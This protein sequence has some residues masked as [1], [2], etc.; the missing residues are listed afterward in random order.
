MFKVPLPK[1]P[2]PK[3]RVARLL[4]VSG[5]RHITP[6][7]IRVT[8]EGPELADIPQ[9]CAGAHC[10]IL[11]PEAGQSR[12]DFQRQ[13]ADGPKPITRTYT[14][15]HMRPDPLQ[16]DVDFVAHGDE[17]PASAWAHRAE[18][19]SFCGFMGPGG[20]KLN[21]YYA[22]WYLVAAD[23][24]ALPVA[25]ATIEAMPDD[26]KGIAIF[27]VTSEA[28]KQDFPTP[29]G[30]ETH[31]LIH[32]DAHHR[33]HAQEEFIRSLDWPEGTVQTCIAGESGV[34]QALRAFLMNEKQLNKRDAYISGYWKIG[35]VEDQHQQA[36]RVGQAG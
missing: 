12:D 26:A 25:A 10:K 9:D 34:I 6:N 20:K 31:W 13:L 27:E 22:D 28:D 17:G 5:A 33:S 30:I 2:L 32:E 23:M 16:M 14:V 36:K 3:K 1:V 11:L 29:A 7:M 24:S 35:L 4:T 19:G 8:F 15:R 18:A 21:T